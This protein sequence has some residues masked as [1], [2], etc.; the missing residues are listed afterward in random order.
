MFVTIIV[1]GVTCSYEQTQSF[2]SRQLTLLKKV[3]CV[4]FSLL[5]CRFVLFIGCMII[6]RYHFRDL[7]SNCHC[8]Q[9]V[10][11]EKRK[12]IRKKGHQKNY[13]ISPPKWLHA[14]W[15]SLTLLLTRLLLFHLLNTH[16]ACLRKSNNEEKSFHFTCSVSERVRHIDFFLLLLFLLALLKSIFLRA[17]KRIKDVFEFIRRGRRRKVS[18]RV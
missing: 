2:K 7:L 8:C 6:S 1:F 15:I 3:M 12:Q 18:T 13:I 16:G 5:Q 11:S 17:A 10:E 9:L 14:H 4:L